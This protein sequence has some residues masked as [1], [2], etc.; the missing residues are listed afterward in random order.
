VHEV[1]R[2]ST[3]RVPEFGR[4][5]Y[6]HD[7]GKSYER[8]EYWLAFF[9]QMARRIVEDLKPQTV[10]DAGCA[11]GI[12]VECLRELGVDAW[13]IDVSKYAID[14]VDDSVKEYCHEGSLAE[15]LPGSVPPRFDLVTC[16]EVVEHMLP[17]DT[18]TAIDNLCGSAE[19]VLFSSS[20]HDYA[21][22]THVNVRPQEEWGALFA[23][24]G[25]L[26][27]LDINPTFVTPWAVLYESAS[28][29]IPELV[30]TYERTLWRYKDEAQQARDTV[31]DLQARLEAGADQEEVVRLHEE[32]VRLK[33]ELLARR[34]V[35]I[36]SEARLAE[37]IGRIAALEAELERYRQLS[38]R[39][40]RVVRSRL[41]RYVI[42]PL[43]AARRKLR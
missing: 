14:N 16:I 27:N 28:M 7:C 25:F 8:N 23:R 4:Y 9:R 3:E 37:S 17:A 38:A 24:R 29:P 26:R 36:G 20:P 39:V 11:L 21:E 34:D 30:R 1:D 5:Y 10:L 2:L 35:V 32:V 43:R 18:D 6:A 33:Q 22:A 15:P 42:A 13:G 31:L 19:R 41:Y 12:L 40:D